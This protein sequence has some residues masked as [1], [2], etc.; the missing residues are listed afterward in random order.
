MRTCAGSREKLSGE[1]DGFSSTARALGARGD[2]PQSR[3]DAFGRAAAVLLLP[4][5]LTDA[6]CLTYSIWQLEPQSL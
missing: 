2:R 5:L 4:Y 6:V 3:S 1:T